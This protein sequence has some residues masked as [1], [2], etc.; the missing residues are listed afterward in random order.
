MA[1]PLPTQSSPCPLLSRVDRRGWRQRCA[2]P[3]ARARPARGAVLTPPSLRAGGS[4]RQ[5]EA[6]PSPPPF[7]SGKEGAGGGLGGELARSARAGINRE[8]SNK[9]E[10]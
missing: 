2:L 3:R 7:H 4:P 1:R 6:L 10:G 9:K 5:R 8:Y